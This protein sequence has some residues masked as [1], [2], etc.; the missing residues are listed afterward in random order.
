[1]RLKSSRNVVSTA[2]CG[3][4][5]HILA[6]DGRNEW[7]CASIREGG[8]M[9]FLL[10]PLLDLFENVGV[11]SGISMISLTALNNVSV[12]FCFLRVWRVS[13]PRLATRD[14]ALADGE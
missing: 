11:I 6:V 3:R 13:N 4:L 7:R 1:M 10:C 14:D 5:F 2:S 9:I 12:F 8:N